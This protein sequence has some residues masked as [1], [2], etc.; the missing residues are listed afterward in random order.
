MFRHDGTL[1]LHDIGMQLDGSRKHRLGFVSHAHADHYAPHDR[2]Y[3]T[4]VTAALLE[5]RFGAT[6]F[7]AMPL[8]ERLRLGKWQL[9]SLPAGH[10][11]GS[12]M[13]L[14]ETDEQKLLYTGDFRLRPALTSEPAQLAPADV[15]VME[16]TFGNPRFRFPDRADV[17]AQL[18]DCI[19]VAL[20]HGQ[21]PVLEAY[22]VG[23]AQ[24]LTCRLSHSG[25]RVLLHPDI[26]AASQLYEQL[27]CSLGSYE[28]LGTAPLEQAVVIRPPRSQRNTPLPLPRRRRVIAVTGWA[29]RYSAAELHADYAFP[30]SDHADFDELLECVEKVEPRVIYCGHGSASFPAELECRGWKAHWLNPRGPAVECS[31]T[32]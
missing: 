13:L 1:E 21:T 15:L 17:F 23:K 24:E 11:F 28:Q 16:C 7:Q 6:Q 9:T 2:I 30:F 19:H 22:A 14:A 4:P 18:L 27:G 20:R 12:A 26:F 3:C 32:G 31:M 5:H 8:G 29:L 10:M 25:L